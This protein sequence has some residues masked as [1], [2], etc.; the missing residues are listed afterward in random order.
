MQTRRADYRY[1]FEPEERVGAEVL[2]LRAVAPVL[3]EIVNLSM[4][5][6]ALRLKE[7]RA[8]LRPGDRVMV[9]AQLPGAVDSLLAPARV[10]H[11]HQAADG[12]RL[13][14]FHF[15]PSANPSLDQARQAEIW[16]CLMAAQ[17][18]SHRKLLGRRNPD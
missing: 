9:R 6:L 7:L 8:D 16:R 4:G 5:G 3:G 15:I 11:Q 12:D 13:L 14:G 18:R 10:V 17:R 1:A 2:P